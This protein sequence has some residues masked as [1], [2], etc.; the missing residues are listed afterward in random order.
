MRSAATGAWQPYAQPFS[1]HKKV[2]AVDA[3]ATSGGTVTVTWREG[4]S[5]EEYTMAAVF[6]G[7]TWSAPG[8]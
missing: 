1:T 5:G 2:R 3:A 4:Y 6:K 8:G 7:G